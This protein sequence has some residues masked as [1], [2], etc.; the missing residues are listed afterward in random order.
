VEE[1][2]Q[3]MRKNSQDITTTS[4]S[5]LSELKL[6]VKTFTSWSLLEKSA[7]NLTS[8]KLQEIC[9]QQ[10]ITTI[11]WTQKYNMSLKWCA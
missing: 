11:Q 4:Q 9:T 1:N 7:L 5:L 8:K 10:W 2:S 3:H 6:W